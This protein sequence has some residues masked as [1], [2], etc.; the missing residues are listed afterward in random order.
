MIRKSLLLLLALMIAPMVHAAT[1]DELLDPEVAFD[2]SVQAIDAGTVRATYTIADGYYMYRDKFVFET[3]TP[4]ASLGEPRYPKGK[5]KNDEFFGKIEAYYNSVSI[6]IPVS[7]VSGKLDLTIKSQGCNEPLGV[8]YPPMTSKVSTQLPSGGGVA[9]LSGLASNLGLG[10][11][12]DDELL[13][14]DQAFMFDM[15]AIDGNNLLGRWLVADGYYLYKD[16]IK[17]TVTSGDGISIS[18]VDLPKGKEKDDEFFGRMEVYYGEVDATVAL[19]RDNLDPTDI[20]VTASYQGCSE[21][22]GV[23]YPPINK[24]ISLPLPSGEAGASSGPKL[25]WADVDLS[26]TDQVLEYLLNSSVGIVILVSV[27]LGLLIAF[28]ACMYPMIPIVSSIIVGHGEQ[29][30]RGK[31]FFLT[32]VYVEA[33]AITFGI[34]GGIMG[35]IGGGVGIQA[36]FQSPWLLIPF[37]ALFVLLALGMFGFYEIQVPS[38]LQSRITAISNQQKGGSL[39]GVG[40]M[41]ALSALIIGPCGGPMLIAMLAY[42]AADTA[43]DAAD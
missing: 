25:A 33:M 12:A 35:G 34:I 23:C 6:D 39:I 22:L 1:E 30:S 40:I 26:N 15:T 41:G 3:T 2:L 31:G 4:G 5:V 10:Q 9:K 29:M 37:S 14:P 24:Q 38:A 7:G 19:A 43:H 11:Q 8:C 27:I 36:Y 42:A 20:V 17:F 21:T 13:P 16:K 28:T 32:L 18:S